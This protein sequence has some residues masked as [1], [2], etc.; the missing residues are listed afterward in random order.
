VLMRGEDNVAPPR[1]DIEVP[2]RDTEA[3]ALA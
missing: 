3:R 2:G 1:E